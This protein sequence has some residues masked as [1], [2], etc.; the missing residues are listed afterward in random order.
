LNAFDE[1]PA[2]IVTDEPDVDGGADFICAT[3]AAE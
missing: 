3:T 1:S 2:G